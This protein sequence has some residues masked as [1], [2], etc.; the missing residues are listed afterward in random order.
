MEKENLMTSKV[1]PIPD[2]YHTL[3]PYLYC[4][5]AAGAIEFYKAAFG[6]TELFRMEGP[7]GK[8]GHAEIKI[9]DSAVMLADESPEMGAMSPNT[10]GGCPFSFL[11]YVDDV[12]TVFGQAVAAGAVVK[13]P[14][15]TEFYGDRR[16]AVKD[17]SGYV[18]YIATHVEDVSPEEI[19]RRAAVQHK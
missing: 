6:A 8:I 11:V 3:T 16:G 12:D 2:G 9:G 10:V 5:G 18:W 14:V 4:K 17:S 1:K 7:G 15:A 13:D 19:A